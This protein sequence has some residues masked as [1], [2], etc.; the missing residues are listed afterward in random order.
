MTARRAALRAV[1]D[2]VADGSGEVDWAAM[3]AQL[4][5]ERDQALL[6]QL[7]VLARIS[8]VQRHETR[9]IDDRA[10][11][12]A[13]RAVARILPIDHGAWGGRGMVERA[14]SRTQTIEIERVEGERWGRFELLDC[15]GRGAFGSVYRA[16]DTHLQRE[17]AVKILHQDRPQDRL[18]EEARA[19][20][21]V[22]H[23][24]VVTVHDAECW[25]G[26]VGICMEFIRGKTLDDIL[27]TQGPRS[28]REAAIIGQD[29]CQALS[30]VHAAG[31]IHRDVKAQNVMREDGGRLVL[32]DFGAGMPRAE[33]QVPPRLT[34]TPLYI[35]PEVLAGAEPSV[36]S[37]IYGLGV[38]LFHLVTGEFPIAG[39]SY[40]ELRRAHR[41]GAVRR[42]RDVAPAVPAWFVRVVE[43]A[44]A[45][46]PQDRYATVGE[47]EKAL[48]QKQP[49]PWA[50]YLAAAAVTLALG[51]GTIAA[52]PLLRGADVQHPLVVLLPLDA[53]LGV[54]PH[55]AYAIT[56]EIYQ[57]LAMVD[58]LLV[59]SPQ[60]AA[61]AKAA[62]LTMSE[63][64]DRLNAAG[65]V[66]GTVSRAGDGLEIRLRLFP[67]GSDSPSWVDRYQATTTDLSPLRRAS[68]LGIATELKV[69][70]SS[71]LARQLGRPASASTEAFDA[72]ARGLHLSARGSRSDLHNALL[73]FERSIHLAP[74]YAPAH[75]ALAHV[76]L[77]LGTNGHRSEW[78]HQAALAKASADR[79]L[80]LDAH[81]AEAHAVAAEV[82]FKRDWDWRAAEAGFRRAISLN[83]SQEFARLRYAH[84][85]AGRGRVDEALEQL[86]IARQL[87]LY[88][89]TAD[90]E[91]VSVLQYARRFAEA[92][93]LALTL[94][95]RVENP[96]AVHVRLGRIF[97]A[98]QRFDS[99]IAEF[100][101]LADSLSGDAYAL[102]E[103]ASAHAAA[104]RTGEAHAI[105]QRLTDRA[106][107]EEISPELFALIHTRLGRFDD[108]FRYLDRAVQVRA[109]RILWLKVDPRWDP[110]RSD[111]RFAVVL[112]RLGL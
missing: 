104:G 58:T 73:E 111:P 18:L 83:A 52:W 2:S 72:Y 67:A 109:T 78:P 66:S 22:D 64:S 71:R 106:R 3:E 97:A 46:H 79:A 69:S 105:L 32:M 19:L 47:L 27:A 87:D 74:A 50:P 70:V 44:L 95:D 102:A 68:V 10:L 48:A 33:N 36:Q 93:T 45:P 94:R 25:D 57:S 42:L 34:G 15:I 40:D 9:G 24:N 38:L 85:L 98:T 30:A 21:R 92:E 62:G 82:A 54:E 59:S 49:W 14:P 112:G 61:N 28:A 89:N 11:H 99:A 56:D 51:A 108:A 103:I 5:G 35:V 17:V 80:E 13:A 6:Q 55:M 101:Q 100:E 26:R 31:L 37:D 91:R 8:D 107:A 39:R 23:P 4:D 20:A 1:I 7:R 43:R 29:L 75:A 60:S 53:G 88:S 81:L 12:Q 84:F 16:F 96:R 63:I 65:V 90:F 76:H 41:D 110:L 77:D 86:E